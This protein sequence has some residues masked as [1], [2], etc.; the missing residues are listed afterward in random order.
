MCVFVIFEIEGRETK[1][2]KTADQF[3]ICP[4]EGKVSQSEQSSEKAGNVTI[5][6]PLHVGREKEPP[7]V[8]RCRIQW[9]L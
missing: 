7:Q 8:L 6:H 3:T 1:L 9:L 2:P 5:V 4:K